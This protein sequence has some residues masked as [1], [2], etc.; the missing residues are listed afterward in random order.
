MT[1]PIRDVASMAPPATTAGIAGAGDGAG[2]GAGAGAEAGGVVESP[3]PPPQPA[4]ASTNNTGNHF[5]VATRDF[6]GTWHLFMCV[7]SGMAQTIT[8]RAQPD[9]RPAAIDAQWGN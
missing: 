6:G 1:V 8:S 3:P 7:S 2:A 9:A 5:K 4:A